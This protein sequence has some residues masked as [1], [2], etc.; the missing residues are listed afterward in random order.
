MKEFAELT[1]D[2][3]MKGTERAVRWAE[4]VIRHKGAKHSKSPALD[5]PEYQFYLLDVVSFC[6]L[7]VLAVGYVLIK[8]EKLLFKL[9]KII[10]GNNKLKTQ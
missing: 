1:N 2:Q 3:L 5:L 4:Y 8:F 9:S 6:I 10:V 7:I